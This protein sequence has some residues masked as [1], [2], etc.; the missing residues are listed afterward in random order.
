MAVLDTV[1]RIFR[2]FKRYT[3]D[4][5]PGEPIGAPLPVGDPQSGV[6]SPK[7]SELRAVFTAILGTAGEDAEAAAAALAELE[8]LYLGAKAADPATDNEGGALATGALYFNTASG[9][10][11]VWNS[12]TWQDQSTALTDGDVTRPKLATA[13]AAS[14]ARNV[15]EFG[16]VG[17]GTADDTAALQAAL[18]YARANKVA[19]FVP[20][21]RYKITST[22]TYHTT[23][24]PTPGDA[25][26]FFAP[27]LAL[28]G[29]GHRTS[30][31][32]NSIAAGGPSLDL[33]SV[34]NQTFQQG[35]YICG[36]G[37]EASGSGANSHGI[38][39]EGTWGQTFERCR[40]EGMNGAGLKIN[41][42][43]DGDGKSSSHVMIKSCYFRS[44]R[45]PAWTSQGGNG[46]VALHTIEDCYIVDNDLSGQTGQ[47]VIDGAIHFDM[48]MCSIAGFGN[49]IPLVRVMKTNITSQTLRFEQGEYGNGCG[50]HFAIDSVSNFVVDGIRHVRRAGEIT[51]QYG[52]YFSGSGGGIADGVV[53]RNVELAIDTSEGGGWTFLYSDVPDADIEVIKP[54]VSSFAAGNVPY[55]IAGAGVNAKLHLDDFDGRTL[56]RK[57]LKK[58]SVEPTSTSTIAPDLLVASWWKIAP[59][60]AGTYTIAVP[61]GPKTDG[62]RITISVVKTAT[63]L[64]N[65]AAAYT[66]RDTIAT[67][68]VTT[69]EFLYDAESISWRQV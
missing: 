64:I 2:E 24:T 39:Y 42:P 68:A 61:T 29:E 31:L 19:L 16:A 54:T 53:I 48:R 23:I 45:G 13:L 36:V 21:G 8:R 6:H 63:I 12:G 43:G 9:K 67:D 47:I 7:K 60:A 10:F 38:E 40:F 69:L 35:G 3:G 25:K 58:K 66:I 27:G 4:G 56:I 26:T 18:D 28:F 44:N 33:Y 57:P 49:N 62:S 46:G 14:V 15:K 32:V 65:F 50:A 11:R 59:T 37:F 22:L 30:V 52:Y 34:T 1:N 5:L 17:N 55:N 51:S 20:T 41:N